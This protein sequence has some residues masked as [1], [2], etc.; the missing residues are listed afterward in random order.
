[1]T[2]DQINNIDLHMIDQLTNLLDVTTMI[3]IAGIEKDDELILQYKKQPL[4]S[5]KNNKVD[6]DLKIHWMTD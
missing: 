6:T 2:V 3:N 4:N 5:T 1:M